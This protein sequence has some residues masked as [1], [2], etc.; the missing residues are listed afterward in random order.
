MLKKNI[1]NIKNVKFNELNI[2]YKCPP[3]NSDF[4][5]CQIQLNQSYIDAAH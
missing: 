4:H 3:E 2:S 1:L 5:I